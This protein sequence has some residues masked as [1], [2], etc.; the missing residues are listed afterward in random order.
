MPVVEMFFKNAQTGKTVAVAVD[1]STTVGAIKSKIEEQESIPAAT[2]RLI[3]AG[4]VRASLSTIYLHRCIRSQ[5]GRRTGAHALQELEDHKSLDEYN[6]AQESTLYLVLRENPNPPAEAAPEP[7]PAPAGAAIV[8]V[9]PIRIKLPSGQF[10]A[11]EGVTSADTIERVKDRMALRETL[12]G[13]AGVAKHDP[14]RPET[15]DYI[16]NQLGTIGFG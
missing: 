10:Y 1:S 6:M 9:V 16:F 5:T 7:A 11:V 4:K 13:F 3:F 2:Q 12:K 14:P 8:P 15:I